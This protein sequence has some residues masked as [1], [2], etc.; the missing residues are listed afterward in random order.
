WAQER[1]T[2]DFCEDGS[3]DANFH[4]EGT[5][6]TNM[7]RPLAFEYRVQLGPRGQGYPILA[8]R[9][10]PAPGDTG[11]T[12]MC[13]Y[14]DQ[15][16]SLMAAIEREKPLLGRPLHEVLSWSRPA[17]AAGCYCDAESRRH[18]W[19]LVLETIQYALA[20]REG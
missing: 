7:G 1:L 10:A 5:T 12:F 20:H 15:R 4:Y 11:H 14:L 17:C 9:C 3:V 19:G 8:Q 18:K 2:L 16:E 13:R 6:C